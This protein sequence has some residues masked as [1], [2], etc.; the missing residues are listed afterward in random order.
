MKLG[1]KSHELLLDQLTAEIRGEV[2]DPSVIRSASDRV[3]SG[4]QNAGKPGLVEPSQ[5]EQIKGCAD[6]QRLM[7]SYLQGGL[8]EARGLLLEEHT[9]ECLTCRREIRHYLHGTSRSNSAADLSPSAKARPR[10][11]SLRWGIAAAVILSMSFVGFLAVRGLQPVRAGRVVIQAA[12]G[13]IYRVSDQEVMPLSAGDEITDGQSIHTGYAS[14]TVIRTGDGSLIEMKGRSQLS[15]SE[16]DRGLM[17]NLE[18][19]N[20]IVQAARQGS[21]HLYVSTRDCTVSVTGTI[22]SLNSSVKGS[23]VSVIEGAVQ[24]DYSGNRESLNPGQQLT[25]S[26]GIESKLVMDDIL[27][28]RDAERYLKLLA[29]FT[30]RRIDSGPGG[31]HPQNRFSTRLLDLQPEATVFYI[32]LPNLSAALSDSN[33]LIEEQIHQNAALRQWWD[34]RREGSGDG[35][36]LSEIVESIGKAA[37]FFGDEI[38]ISFGIN[39]EGQAEGMLVMAELSDSAEFR[40]FLQNQNVASSPAPTGGVRMRLI[41]GLVGRESQTAGSAARKEIPVAIHDNI[42][43]ASDDPEHLRT[44]GAARE[45]ATGTRF[46]ETRFHSRISA[47]YSEGVGIILA[48]DLNRIIT[49]SEGGDSRGDKDRAEAYDRLGLSDLEY[50]ILELRADGGLARNRAVLTFAEPRRGISSWLAPPGPMGSLEFIS[51]DANVVAAFVV[52]N[53]RSFVDDL[54]TSLKSIDPDLSEQLK[55]FEAQARA[56]LR[57]D[58]AEPLGG[59]FAVA[60]DGPLLPTPSW[61]AIFEVYDPARLQ[62]GIERAVEEINRRAGAEGKP[63]LLLERT[64]Q[65]GRAFYR[66]RFGNDGPD[67]SYAFA[68]GYLIAAPSHA[69]I[70]RAIRYRQSG[71]TLVHSPRFASL[72]PEDNGSDFSAFFYHDFSRL[73]DPLA[74][75]GRGGSLAQAL[76]PTLIY[77]NASGDRITFA[78]SSQPASSSGSLLRLPGYF[79]LP[80][81]LEEAAPSR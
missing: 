58:F 54:L 35:P 65:G 32:A 20:I 18:R 38:A 26:S 22:F 46:T 75:R 2:I 55:E 68:S 13:P 77:A 69:L 80:R 50:L 73:L 44:A 27:W 23:R 56:D 52:N 21:R 19:G 60:V 14:T 40:A 70:D 30:D 4:I 79:Q 67:L 16:S 74:R 62:R 11:A 41:D 57:E 39:S 10:R 37:A 31:A 33:S 24:V 43:I 8:S 47:L 12:E 59:E 66:L 61:K 48:A 81:I 6:F 7:P 17:I 34:S 53:P 36:A 1:K 63:G 51:P 42:F 15:V 25:T 28:S 29:A 78:A 5:V 72:L 3:W 9:R 71:Y 64:D 76:P 45:G 49:Q